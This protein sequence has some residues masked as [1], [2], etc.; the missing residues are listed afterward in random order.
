M[1]R[2]PWR[3]LVAS[4]AVCGVTTL[5]YVLWNPGL[6]V[7]DGRHDRARNGIWIQHGWLGDD[8]WF[9]RN[10]KRDRIP[11]FRSPDRIRAFADRLRAHG[12]SDVFPHLCPAGPDGRLPPVDDAQASRFLDAFAGFRVM[13]WIGGI[14]GSNAFPGSPVWRREFVQ[15]VR[16]LL[17]RH[18][19]LA[20][21]HVNIEPC[22]SGDV[23]F[24]DLLEEFRRAL[25]S[26]KVLSVAAYPPPTAWHPHPDVHWD[27]SYFRAVASRSDQMAVMMYD[28]GLRIEKVYVNLMSAW[29]REA[30]QWS[31]RTDVLLGLPAYDD[32]DVGYHRPEVENLASALAGV[33]AGLESF[34]AMPAN[35]QGTALYSE[36]EMEDAEWRTYR[37]RYARPA[38][39]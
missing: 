18:P 28:T 37:E 34:G 1:L 22:P 11:E 24:L 20:G 3:T 29:T 32:A 4:A 33:H 5:A 6:D 17:A 12:I 27:E 2:P 38:P 16:E 19:R 31:G 36:W 23:G 35:Y 9:E 14:R 13:P 39:R 26:G 10:G 21:F 30:V 15:A 25:P 7:T 8:G